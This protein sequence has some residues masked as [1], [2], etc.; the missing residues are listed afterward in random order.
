[1]LNLRKIAGGAMIAALLLSPAAFAP[2]HA[3]N[4]T[5]DQ[6]LLWHAVKGDLPRRA[7]KAVSEGKLDKARAL[8]VKAFKKPYAEKQRGQ[9]YANLCALDVLSGSYDRAQS[10]CS[11]ALEINSKDWTALNN[12][13]VALYHAGQVHAAIKDIETA[14][15]VN[16]GDQVLQNNLKKISADSANTVVKN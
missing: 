11:K 13:A 8:Y 10:L 16:D 1:M 12:R 7:M 6:S 15:N 14:L 4:V 5:L 2:A 3:E 9:L